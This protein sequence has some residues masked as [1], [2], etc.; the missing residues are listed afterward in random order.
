MVSIDPHGVTRKGLSETVVCVGAVRTHASE[1][2]LAQPLLRDAA[3]AAAVRLG[4]LCG[5]SS[6]SVEMMIIDL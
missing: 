5:W 3:G 1:R 6:W 4:L 2:S